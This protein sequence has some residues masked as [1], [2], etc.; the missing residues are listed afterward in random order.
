MHE[1]ITQLNNVSTHPDLNIPEHLKGTE[2]HLAEEGLWAE[3]SS[4]KFLFLGHLT[5]VAS[6]LDLHII[7]RVH[8]DK[9]QRMLERYLKGKGFAYTR[10]REEMGGALEISMVKESLS[11]GIH[12]TDSVRDLYRPP[13]GILA[14][15]PSVNL[16]SVCMQHIRTTYTRNGSLLPV[17]WLFVANTSE[18]IEHCLPDLPPVDRLRLLIQYTADLHDAVGDLQ[19]DAL[20]VHEDVDEIVVFLVDSFASWPLAPIEPLHAVS[21]EESDEPISSS[22][23]PAA[24][25]QKRGLVSCN[26]YIISAYVLL[27]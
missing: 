10:P 27:F 16:R 21:M 17:I 5:E 1:M 23:E 4:A 6:L 8:D 2:S 24:P 15:T 18:H 11:F 9:A 19:D 3:Y 26:A 13:A 22:D 14:L 7:L 25:T 20:G 12:Y